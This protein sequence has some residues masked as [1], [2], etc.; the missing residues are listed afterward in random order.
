MAESRIMLS[1]ATILSHEAVSVWDTGL[2]IRR[3]R[4]QIFYRWRLARPVTFRG[5]TYTDLNALDVDE[6]EEVTVQIQR[7]CEGSFSTI[8]T[9]H[10]NAG[11]WRDNRDDCEITV[12]V[13]TNDQYECFLT[14]WETPINLYALGVV[15]VRPYPI[16]ELYVHDQAYQECAECGTIVPIGDPANWCAEPEYIGCTA[17]IN[18]CVGGETTDAYTGYHRMEAPGTCDGTTPVAPTPDDYWTLLDDDCPTGSTWWRCPGGDVNTTTAPLPYGRLFADVLDAIFLPCGL[19]VVSDFFDINPDATAPDNAAYDFAA[20]YLQNMTVHQKS[21]VKRPYSSDPAQSKQWDMQ[22]EQ[23]LNDLRILFNVYWTINTAGDEI[24]LEHITYFE[25]AG[26]LDCTADPQR[27]DTEREVDDNVKS[28]FFQYVDPDSSSAYFLGSP[29]V[30]DCGKE[31]KERRCQLFSTDV[32]FIQNTNSEGFADSGF[33]LCS[34]E[35]TGDERYLVRD[36]R[37]LAFTELHENLH[38]HYRY[39]KTGTLNGDPVTFDSYVPT[40]KQPTFGHTLCCGDV[41]DE[42][43]PVTTQIGAGFIEAAVYTIETDRILLN[44]KH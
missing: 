6:C 29:I 14:N 4:E 32:V 34:T 2:E 5:L 33:V 30:Y 22:P 38:R 26:G 11:D 27:L 18:E 28:E 41:F 39:W 35:G 25:Q 7:R 9:G 44:I 36:N 1:S 23:L 12:T 37:P 16:T 17:S 31:K 19:T 8:L 15:P 40:L 43:K 42:N 20:L 24:R 21:D 10:F 3:E 13:V